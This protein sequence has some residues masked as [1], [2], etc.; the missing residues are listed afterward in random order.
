MLIIPKLLEDFL[1]LFVFLLPFIGVVVW[2]VMLF[3]SIAGLLIIT[4]RY[5]YPSTSSSKNSHKTENSDLVTEPISLQHHQKTY[6]TTG[7]SSNLTSNLPG[8]SVLRPLKG[9]DSNLFD[10][11]ASSFNL[12]YPKFELIFSVASAS[13]PAVAIVE[14]LQEMYPKVDAKLI[15]GEKI[16]GANPKIN[17]LIRGFEIAKYDIIWTLDSNVRTE[18]GCLSRSVE[19]L[20]EPQ[21]GLV[22]H[23]PAIHRADSFASNLEWC[24][25]NSTHSKMYI[26]LNWLVIDSCIVGKSMVFRKHDLMRAAARASNAFGWPKKHSVSYCG[27]FSDPNKALGYYGQFMAEDNFIGMSLMRIGLKHKMTSDLAVQIVGSSMTIKEYAIRRMRWTRT[28]MFASPVATAH[29]PVT[30]MVL[31]GL[32]ACWGFYKLFNVSPW[33]FLPIHVGIWLG[34]DVIIG[35]TLDPDAKGFPLSAWL[36]RE[37]LALPL[38]IWSFFGLTVDWRGTIYHL[39]RDGTVITKTTGKK[40]AEISN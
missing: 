20:S 4:N 30:E 16:V 6:G 5:S 25:I 39:R 18:P 19:A 3:F 29:E 38:Y 1:N 21:V 8:V 27:D 17:N 23:L 2:F 28:R 26:T 14:R 11:L 24:Y 31:N 36:A 22:H 15:I 12:D 9:V 33:V 35:K 32:L 10:N 40:K 37:F 34:T 13:D 7:N